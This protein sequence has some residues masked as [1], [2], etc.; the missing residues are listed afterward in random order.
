MFTIAHFLLLN[1]CC[2]VFQVT[3]HYIKSVNN[4][5]YVSLPLLHC[6]NCLMCYLLIIK[7]VPVYCV[8]LLF[9]QRL[10]LKSRTSFFKGVTIHFRDC[11]INNNIEIR[12]LHSLL[13]CSHKIERIWY[14]S[15]IKSFTLINKYI[16]ENGYS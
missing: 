9:Y 10:S 13:L 7:Q 1:G 8:I 14:E 15:Y 11:L 4:Y 16:H 2:T 5:K 6:G 3:C 12:Y